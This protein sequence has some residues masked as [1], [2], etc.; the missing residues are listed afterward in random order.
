MLYCTESGTTMPLNSHRPGSPLR[1]LRNTKVRVMTVAGILVLCV[2]AVAI[3][4]AC[5]PRSEP[6]ADS[7]ALLQR[8]AMARLAVTDFSLD[9]LNGSLPLAAGSANA[10][11]SE[12][13]ASMLGRGYEGKSLG[14]WKVGE[15]KPQPELI[16]QS[17]GG[18]A[19]SA[20]APER[21]ERRQV[22]SESPTKAKG[23]AAGEQHRGLLSAPRLL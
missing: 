6:K 22:Q 5:N 2:L 9:K 4:V 20:V 17:V 15:R 14:T 7:L 8:E 3:G 12:L 1:D 11:V 16:R 19:K 13:L 23:S 10:S 21:L 18:E